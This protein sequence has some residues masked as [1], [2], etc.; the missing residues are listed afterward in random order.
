M[1]TKQPVRQS[2]Q[3]ETG[4]EELL[5]TLVDL[6]VKYIFANLG[7][8]YPAI[9][10]AFAK[11]RATGRAMPEVI[12]CQHEIVAVSA[13]QA[14]AQIT[15]QPQAVFVHVDVGTANM[16]GTV[17]NAAR[18][19]TPIFIFAGQSPWT[20]RGE[21]LGSR[22]NPVQ[23]VQDAPEQAS[24]VRQYTKWAYEVKTPVNL[25]QVVQRAFEVATAEPAGPVYLMAAREPLEARVETR[26]EAPRA[27]LVPPV[28][29]LPDEG[30][31]RTVAEWLTQAERP[32]IL[33]SYLGRNAAAVEPLVALAERLAIPVLEVSAYF[34]NFPRDHELH[35]GTRA[36]QFLP[37]ADLVFVIDSDVPWLPA[38]TRPRTG[39]RV[40]H[41]D[42][43]AV[44]A[45]VSLIDIP[46]DIRLEGS[47]ELAL[48]RLLELVPA[49]SANGQTDRVA[50]RRE[51]VR[52]ER[53]KLRQQRDAA[54][55]PNQGRIT[56]PL[57]AATVGRILADDAIVLDE[58]VSNSAVN[59][60]LTA[61]SRP[62]SYFGSGG[63]SLGW[64]VGAALGA[65]LAAGERDVV[66]TVGD[67][68]FVFGAPTAAFWAAR[69]Y[70]LPFLT[71]IYN[72]VGWNAVKG[73]ALD[74]HPEG[75]AQQSND[76]TASFDPPS[77]LGMVAAA[78]G[79]YTERVSDPD[80]LEAALRRGLEETRRGR[81]A[82]IDVQIVPI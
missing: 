6:G 19:R 5:D 70:K 58:S 79:A 27:R 52:G 7:T 30:A 26:A 41:L 28:P 11:S 8:D 33:T 76:F 24:L 55:L 20:T 12:I 13:A 36:A 35:L 80:E 9:V 59:L 23:F 18:G 47:S 1:Q 60:P 43:D 31:L 25:R 45:D 63:S 42:V 75:Y 62:A 29:S 2:A 46:A 74:Q 77:D 10:E 57:L 39:A 14:Y 69:R 53:E 34:L 72:N 40:V 67:G 3:V 44:K 61:R 51:W 50:A 38:V 16:G 4:A 81:A 49:T 64:G 78:A 32:L 54:M 17:H 73:A 22:T 65:K 37:E 82:V 71:V 68:A 56:A 66:L 21:M 15:R 48:R